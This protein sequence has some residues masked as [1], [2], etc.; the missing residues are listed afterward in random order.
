MQ[1]QVAVVGGGAGKLTGTLEDIDVID[2][3]QDDMNRLFDR[4]NRG[5]KITGKQIEAFVPVIR[6]QQLLKFFATSLKGDKIQD[7]EL[8][9]LTQ[10]I[11]RNKFQ[12]ENKLL[13]MELYP[14]LTTEGSS[15]EKENFLD[16]FVF[17][18]DRS[19]VAKNLKIYG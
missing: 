1:P 12:D 14:M 11:K 7:F 16:A 5:K 13:A 8:P 3:D 19:E 17:R 4:L 15:F 9:H 18:N 6:T 10:A 2:G